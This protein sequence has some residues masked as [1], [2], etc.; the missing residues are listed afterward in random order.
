MD[1]S[2]E[3]RFAVL[4]LVLLNTSSGLL[5]IGSDHLAA[6]ASH[7]FPILAA[8]D[9]YLEWPGPVDKVAQPDWAALAS[10]QIRKHVISL[11]CKSWTEQKRPV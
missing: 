9:V 7:H 1:P 2:M 4:D 8:V 11:F 5:S 3:D 10:L 6:I